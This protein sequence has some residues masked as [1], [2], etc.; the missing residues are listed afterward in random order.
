[1]A[2]INKN[3]D[4]FLFAEDPGAAN[5]IIN[6]PDKLNHKSLTCYIAASGSAVNYFQDRGQKINAVISNDNLDNI[7]QD[8]N[9]KLII[10]GTA[11][12]INTPSHQIINV[13]RNLGIKSV[14]IVDSCIFALERFKG[15]SSD[16]FNHVPDWLIV[17]D[18]R[19][20]NCFMEAGFPER[21]LHI[22]SPPHF[23]F[24]K[25]K[26]DEF[27]RIGKS[28]IKKLKF[29]LFPDN[30]PVVVFGAE[31][32]TG[33]DD[34]KFFRNSDYM[35]SGRG[36]SNKRTEIVMEE[37]LDSVNSLPISTYKVLRLHP[38]QKIS[39]YND[40]LEEF[41]YI[42]HGGDCSELIYVSNLVVGMSS[43]LLAESFIMGTPTL[44]ILPK[45]E[46]KEWLPLESI[47]FVFTKKD[48]LKNLS[49]ILILSKNNICQKDIQFK[50][51][52]SMIDFINSLI[53]DK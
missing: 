51:H 34:S 50:G 10:V 40:Y 26:R 42:S 18:I 47:P 4:I 30:K 45:I 29:P 16:P 5:W 39:N 44:S 46:E 52:N 21:K 43:M 31:L 33:F 8:I 37:F 3:I 1:M 53:K 25:N 36:V 11:E 12:N 32:S 35:L 38:K 48:L 41:D 17:P 13:A 14:G 27:R 19:T 22:F 15:E 7:V 28:V 24:I 23:D 9:P 6:L 49:E 2:N 20:S